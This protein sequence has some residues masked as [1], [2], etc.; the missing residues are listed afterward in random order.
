M[1]VPDRSRASESEA[2]PL[3]GVRVLD[4]T[5]NIAGPFGGAVLA[6]L[7]AEVIKI[8]IPSGDPARSMAPLDGD[9]SAYFHIVNRNK[10][11][12]TVDLKSTQGRAVLETLL[13]TTDVFL[14]NFLPPRLET[15]GLLPEDLMQQ[16]PRLIIGNLSSYGSTGPDSPWPGYDATVQART[17]I[18]HVTGEPNGRP[19]RTGV[20]VLDIGAGTWLALGI[21][22]ALVQ[23]DRT[24]KGSL[25]E[26]SLFETG[27]LWVSYHV[28]ANELTGKASVRSGSGHPTFSPYGIF[29]TKDGE[30]C[31]GVGNNNIF[32]KLCNLIDRRDLIK[33][34]RFINNVDRVTH[35]PEL[36]ME[37]EIG[38]SQ[39]DANYW[40]KSLGAAGV[41]ADRVVLPEDL[42]HDEQARAMNIMLEYPDDSTRV[43]MIPGLP[44]RFDGIR[45]P[46][47]IPAPHRD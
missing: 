9:R 24:G 13:D 7:G 39:H 2:L 44:L 42:L 12:T 16:R 47:R 19:V 18:M 17:G 32:S 8:E 11:V 29:T 46:I 26:T 15:L 30:I 41:P 34:P 3:S 1:T 20:S 45:P 27:A 33:D 38:L 4:A 21:L 25:V 31:I 10:V 23:R 22:A 37:I 28:A 36:K 43:K 14:T 35:V 5:A 40:A 6:D